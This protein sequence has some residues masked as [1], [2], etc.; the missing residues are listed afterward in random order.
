MRS[1]FIV[2]FV[3][4][5]RPLSSTFWVAKSML[6]ANGGA[7]HLRPR[8]RNPS[9]RLRCRLVQLVNLDRTDAGPVA[10]SADDGRVCPGG[11][12]LEHG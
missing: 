6:M 5:N 7:T 9:V 4:I 8:T 10:H 12:S 11:E 2:P 3:S 1:A